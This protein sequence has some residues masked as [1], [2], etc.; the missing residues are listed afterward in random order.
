MV[1]SRWG[2]ALSAAVLAAGSAAASVHASDAHLAPASAGASKFA[3]SQN[4]RDLPPARPEPNSTLP[5]EWIRD[6]D[7]LPRSK[8]PFSPG[9]RLDG[10]LQES[11]TTPLSVPL[12]PSPSGSFTAL[13]ADEAA[14]VGGR[15]APPDTVGDVGPNHYV[16]AVNTVLRVFD[17][18]GNVLSPIVSLGSFFSPLGSGCN[19]QFGDPTVLYDSMADRWL[20][21][22]F[23]LPNGFQPPF[24][25]CIAISQ[26][27][28]PTGSFYLYDFVM[29]NKV[30][31]Y[32]HFGVWPDG[33]YMSDNQFS[34]G[35]GSWAG[36]GFL[37]FD[38]T[39]MLAGDSS[40]T[41][42]YFDYYPIDPTAGGMLPTDLDG[43][44][45]P[46]AGTPNFFMEFRNTA[47][48]DPADALRIYVFHA[49][50][51][52]PGNST[53]TVLPDLV[54]ADFDAR[55]PATRADIEE[56]PPAVSGDYVDAIPDRMMHRIAYRTLA[57]GIQSFV[58]NWTVNVSG[59]NPGGSSTYQA[60]VRF[61]ELRRDP[62]TGT[63]T[64]QNQVTYAPG[65]GNGATGR[66]VWM[67][68]AAQ[69]NQGNS[70]V[71]F[72]ASS[73]TLFPSILWAGRLAGDPAD[74][75]AQGEATV[76]TGIGSQIGSANRW[77]DYS[78]LTVDPSDD[79][80]FFYTQEYY[81][82]NNSFDWVTSVAK[83]AYPGCTPAAQGTV[84][85]VVTECATG[86]PLAGAVVSDGLGHVRVTDAS[87][88][89]SMILPPGPYTLT[90]T[91]PPF[92]AGGGPVTITN[93]ST[94]TFDACLTGVP[95][96]ASS[97]ATVTAESCLPPNNVPDPGETVTVSFCV[98]NSGGADTTDLV[99]TL[100]PSGGVVNPPA[101]ADFGV[102]TAGGPAVCRDFVF[103][104]DPALGCGDTLT[105]TL[106]LADA[107]TAVG[108]VSQDFR[109][110][111][112]IGALAQNFDGA[113]P[114]GLPS[115]WTASNAAGPSP[116]WVTTTTGPDS[117]PNAAF[118]NDPAVVSDKRL[119]SPSINISSPS[120]Q[121]TFH[122][123]FSF[124][125]GFDGGV[126]EI[127]VGGAPFQDVLAA[128]G[129]FLAGGYNGTIDASTGN[130]LAGR[131]AWTGESLGYVT[132]V[133]ALPASAAGSSVVLRWRMGS[134]NGMADVG[135][136]VDT[137]TVVNGFLCCSAPTP[138]A[139]A[140]DMHVVTPPSNVN[141]VWEPGETI[142]VEPA[143]LNNSAATVAL[144]GTLSNLTGPSGATYTIP[145]GAASYGS[146]PSGAG[147]SCTAAGDCYAVSVD[148]PATRPAPHWDATVD[149][150]LSTGLSKTWTLHVGSSFADVPTSNLF[151][152]YVEDIFH[153]GITG[154][155][156][157]G[158]YCPTDPVTRAQ[159]SVFL[160]K[161]KHGSSYVPPTCMGVFA[162]VPCPSQ[163]AN[164]I[165]QLAAEGITAGCDASNYC[166]NDPVTRAQMAVFLLKAKHGSSYVPPTCVGTFADVPCPS[167]FANWIEE[168]AAEGITAGCDAS[169][170]CPSAPNTRGQM[171]VFLAKTFGLLLYG[172]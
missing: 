69:D 84:S 163:F 46:P 76:V 60:G 109:T 131:S 137:I 79:C 85:G 11:E 161:A 29:P 92:L 158:L 168:L 98:Q 133:V 126:L 113:V 87:G 124:E 77:G 139:V 159:M 53:L 136:S 63:F 42:I 37:A 82:N 67:G 52:T 146:L 105:A 149:E 24:H 47:Y 80:T 50:F 8:G 57:G 12:M 64:I 13:T 153:H 129:S 99:A 19:G 169:N 165:E 142:A 66:N 5:A 68:S 156:V 6:N 41:Y 118:V 27:P 61:E 117:P 155:C 112:P 122:H 32:P 59:V 95:V 83:G 162:D 171:A 152:A 33:Y 96:L 62:G 97:G 44:T 135:W 40:A 154:G 45:P 55:A 48:G 100:Q 140:V 20:I 114:P 23:G 49:D 125:T 143:Y 28:D 70:V 144:G 78:A 18:N 103:A 93:G 38:R 71:G 72:S 147:G 58:A 30:N 102:V 65:S 148:A 111:V 107:G 7:R 4:L 167:Q 25:Q 115:G 26:T 104:V 75:L 81:A 36:A 73:T 91:D 127:S 141:G 128:G 164:W 9:P 34:I 123:N 22:Q 14:G 172:P 130:P 157:S 151:Y 31:D 170:Y 94:T 106:S 3:V 138:T 35:G 43:L 21:S 166:P 121:L 2:R 134:D 110:G 17:K 86:T 108:S 90:I 145:D 39:K 88:A 1:T 150:L 89:Y 51:G 120:A 15:F 74:S 119:D 101:P 132:T 10:A 54:V 16:Q 116:L 56:P 160:L